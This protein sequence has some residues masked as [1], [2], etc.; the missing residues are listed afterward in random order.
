MAIWGGI[1]VL[2]WWV[3]GSL[4]IISNR[5][6]LDRVTLSGGG[7]GDIG[8]RSPAV[9]AELNLLKLEGNESWPFIAV[10]VKS[11]TGDRL[12]GENRI[13]KVDDESDSEDEEKGEV[14]FGS[15]FVFDLVARRVS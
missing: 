11:I 4:A 3:S 6:G 2:E 10:G 5:V 9:R 7:G 14:L 8:F 1:W 15:V 13:L 12:P